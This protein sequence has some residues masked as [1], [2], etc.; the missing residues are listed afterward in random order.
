MLKI[1][2]Y[3]DNEYYNIATMLNKTEEEWHPLNNENI[4]VNFYNTGWDS[5]LVEINICKHKIIEYNFPVMLLHKIIHE[6]NDY[7]YVYTNEMLLDDI[8]KE[9]KKYL[10]RTIDDIFEECYKECTM[11]ELNEIANIWNESHNFEEWR[12]LE[13]EA[14]GIW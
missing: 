12:D 1:E 8:N 10:N 5:I 3:A 9:V 11:E 2:Y 13:R 7:K 4:N 6:E 14:L